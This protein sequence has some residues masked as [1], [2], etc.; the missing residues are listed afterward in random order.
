[1]SVFWGAFGV[2]YHKEGSQKSPRPLSFAFFC[3][4]FFLRFFFKN[5]TRFRGWLLC[6][7]VSPLF[8]F[9]L[10]L[11]QRPF[12]FCG[13]WL[14][15]T[16]AGFRRPFFSRPFA[17]RRF[18]PRFSFP[19]APPRPP[20]RPAFRPPPLPIFHRGAAFGAGPV[21]ASPARAPPESVF[22][23]ARFFGG[24]RRPH[25]R[26]RLDRAAAPAG[27]FAEGRRAGSRAGCRRPSETAEGEYFAGGGY[28]ARARAR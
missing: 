5:K 11:F 10:F 20:R 2:N 9:A 6:F 1:M 19:R 22:F 26:D 3:A 18:R 27:G 25:A 17:R 13:L 7:G 4:G 14:R 23:R 8:F 28:D 15:A 24:R 16:G 12:S 21:R